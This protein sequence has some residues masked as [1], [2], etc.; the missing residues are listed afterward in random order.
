MY[1]ERRRKDDLEQGIEDGDEELLF[2]PQVIKDIKSMSQ[3][4]GSSDVERMQ[5]LLK[6]RVA[7]AGA[8]AAPS[9]GKADGPS[10]R[11]PRR[12]RVASR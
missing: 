5:T 4:L 3:R 1:L 2:D 12:W 6:I 9:P 8:N 11:R 10:L 7:K